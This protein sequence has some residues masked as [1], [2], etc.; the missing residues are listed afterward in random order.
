MPD[1]TASVS[2]QIVADV[3]DATEAA[4]TELIEAVV[5][6]RARRSDTPLPRLLDAALRRNL[7]TLRPRALDSATDRGQGGVLFSNGATG[8]H[9]GIR[10]RAPPMGVTMTPPPLQNDPL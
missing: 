1:P 9:A 6:I 8:A 7:D 5:D 2:I 4:L 3:D 10:E